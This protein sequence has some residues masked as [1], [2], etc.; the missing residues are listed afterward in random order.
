MTNRAAALWV[1]VVLIA[2]GYLAMRVAD[3][4]AFRTD[5]LALLPQEQQDP[6]AQ[7]ANDLV[8][9]ALSRQ[10]L[11]LVGAADRD[12]ARN[13]ASG[14]SVA[15]AESGLIELTTDAFGEDRLRKIA[16]F[17]FPYRRGLLSDTDRDHLR[18]GRPEAVAAAA[19][20]QI[21]GL[22]GLANAELLRHDPFLLLPGFLTDLP[23]PLSRFLPDDGMLSLH[24]GNRT[25]ILIGGRLAGDPYSLELQ[26]KLASVLDAK[27]SAERQQDPDLRI[28]RVGAVFFA[29]AGAKQ[30]MTEASTIGLVS[31]MGAALLVLILF[32]TLRPLLLTVIA[33]GTGTLVAASACLALFGELHV[34][35][36]LF[37][38]SLI[39]VTA[40]YSLQYLTEIFAPGAS[41]SRERMRRVFAGITLATVTVV[42]GYV[43]LLLAPLPG[44]RQ[45][46]ALSVVGLLASWITIVLWFPVIDGTKPSR[47]PRLALRAVDRYLA[48]WDSA[49]R[50]RRLGL[51]ALGVL[52][53]VAGLL[54]LQPDDDIRRM[55]A[56]SA[57]LR[58]EQAEAQSLLGTSASMQ[59]FLVEAADD[60]TA[61]QRE[62]ALLARLEPLVVKGALAGFQ[63]PAHYVP[64]AARQRENR[65]LVRRFLDGAMLQAQLQ[66]IGLSTVDWSADESSGLLTLSEAI[67]PDA[68]LSFL[69]ALVLGD[70]QGA[71]HAVKLDAV[72]DYAALGA[73]AAGLP[74]IRFVDPVG[75][76]SALL[77]KYRNRTLLLLGLSGILLAALLMWR[78]GVAG[79]LKVMLSPMLAVLMAPAIRAL[80]GGS[81]T[82]FDGMALVLVLAIGVNYSVFMAETTKVRERV[83]MLAVIAAGCIAL[84]SFG[85]LAVSE[86]QAVHGFG[87]TMAVGIF[88]AVLLSPIARGASPRLRFT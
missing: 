14:I 38:V 16:A 17:Y 11:I 8:T 65:E 28:L 43:T 30:A 77:A 61:L 20:S 6:A 86:V 23:L 15:I 54:R 68:P 29:K 75:D 57:E 19:L 59:F 21:Y 40:D 71:L 69:S 35:A 79:G 53:A 33:I 32:G 5:L 12:R 74:G 42:L 25:W 1:V 52:V 44:L 24:D 45:I 60:E 4:L 70:G 63:A 49:P 41:T 78:Y 36:L 73:A 84:L 81:F 87:A 37:G 85:L 2:A 72:K 31:T 58:G 9:A 34:L 7:R 26:D 13:A 3:G 48:L 66:Q 51:L 27:I 56:L 50:G 64:S 22:V 82:F 18:E 88:V 76:F 47:E 55:Q 46:A 39:G 80:A 83:T 62:E 10:T 67:E